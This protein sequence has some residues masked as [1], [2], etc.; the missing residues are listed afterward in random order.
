MFYNLK[1]LHILF[2]HSD[3][4]VYNGFNMH[5]YALVCPIEFAISESYI[6]RKYF[7]KIVYKKI[8]YKCY[9]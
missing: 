7:Y 1:Y 5:Q 9:N 3:K 2:L 6:F 8:G 4:S